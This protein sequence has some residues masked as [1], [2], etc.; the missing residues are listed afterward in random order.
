[1]W[2]K[3]K[4]NDSGIVK[5]KTAKVWVVTRKK[6][7]RAEQLNTYIVSLGNQN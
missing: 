7:S 5:T 1:M 2:C 6:A 3:I 4:V